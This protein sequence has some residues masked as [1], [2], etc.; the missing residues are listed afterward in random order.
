MDGFNLESGNRLH[1]DQ[2]RVQAL[3]CGADGDSAASDGAAE[4]SQRLPADASRAS[5]GGSPQMEKAATHLCQLDERSL[6]RECALRVHHRNLPSYAAGSLAS[7][8]DSD[9]T[10]GTFGE[11]RPENPLA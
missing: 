4:L 8:S 3:L 11:L 5:P 10:L 7:I 6:P 1:E 2:S 9:K